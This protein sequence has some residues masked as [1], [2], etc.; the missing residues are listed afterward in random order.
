MGR[1]NA[2]GRPE[3]SN[4][5]RSQGK[6]LERSGLRPGIAEGHGQGKGAAMDGPQTARVPLPGDDGGVG[7]R[8]G[9]GP[10]GSLMESGVSAAAA[11]AAAIEEALAAGGGTTVEDVLGPRGDGGSSVGDGSATDGTLSRAKRGSIGSIVV[12]R[13]P[14]GQESMGLDARGDIENGQTGGGSSG[15]LSGRGRGSPAELIAA[16]LPSG[17]GVPL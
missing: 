9:T 2:R 5:S 10:R 11:A 16:G 12:E 6:A 14:G 17:A 8:A 3:A 13:L 1:L 4:R 7:S 15:D